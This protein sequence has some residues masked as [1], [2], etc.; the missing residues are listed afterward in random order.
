MDTKTLNIALPRAL[1]KKI[2]E[3]AKREYRNRSELIREAVRTYLRDLDEWEDIFAYGKR[4]GKKLGI[5]SEK[6]VDDVVYEFR[7]GRKPH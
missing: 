2:D 1:V 3:V 7:H 5:T 4:V 6:Q